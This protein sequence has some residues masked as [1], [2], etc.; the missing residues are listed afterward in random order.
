MSIR[1]AHL[2][3]LHFGREIPEL[4]EGLLEDLRAEKPA[5][6]IISGDLTQRARYEEFH[7]AGKFISRLPCPSL[8]VPG[9]HDIPLFNLWERMCSPLRRFETLIESDPYP[10]RRIPPFVVVGLNSV[11]PYRWKEGAV[12][13]GDLAGVAARLGLQP[14]EAVRM[15]VMHHPLLQASR[16]S[17]A[18]LDDLCDLGIRVMLS[19]HLHQGSFEDL[20]LGGSRIGNSLLWVQAGTAI[21]RRTREEPNSYNL[22]IAESDELE[23]SVRAWTGDG[24]MERKRQTFP[25]IVSRTSK[26]LAG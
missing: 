24:F 1:I 22:L 13:P 14:P 5:L 4:V 18:L 21:S 2:S 23:V 25:G 16:S 11:V 8:V 3:D 20:P 12:S 6:A 26:G 17:R 19:G 9:N 7:R 15:V 10:V